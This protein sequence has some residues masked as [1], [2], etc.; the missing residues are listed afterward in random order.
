MCNR[1]TSSS[2]LI[3]VLLTT[4]KA[5]LQTAG[6]IST[7]RGAGCAA[8]R[9]F[10]GRA[11]SIGHFMCAEECPAGAAQCDGLPELL[12]WAAAHGAQCDRLQSDNT[13][14]IRGLTATTNIPGGSVIVS[15]PRSLTLSVSASQSCPS[16]H[17]IPQDVWSSSV[18]Y[19]SLVTLQTSRLG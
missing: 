1:R 9:N 12:T 3:S 14:A 19:D 17:L 2:I 18:K 6:T 15:L 11:C 5:Q 16:P 4:V 10:A 13:L 7:S 8:L